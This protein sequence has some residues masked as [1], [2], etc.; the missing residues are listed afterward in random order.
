MESNDKS[1]V[2]PFKFGQI[3]PEKETL[4]TQSSSGFTPMKFDL[5]VSEEE[6]RQNREFEASSGFS[7][8]KVVREH[9]GLAAQEKRDFEERVQKEVQ[10]QL[11]QIK[12]QA[13]EEGFAEG[14]NAG[15][16]KAYAQTLV[17]L[18]DKVDELSSVLSSLQT[19]AHTT[20]EQNKANAYKMVKNLTKWVLLK[21]MDNQD[22]LERLLEKLIY[23]INTKSNL[24]VKVNEN[25]FNY[26]PEIIKK[27]ESRLGELEN[28][29]VKVDQVQSHAGII[30]ESENGIVDG[31][32]ES[33][34]AALDSLFE[35]VEAHESVS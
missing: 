4:H 1:E 2:K 35:S 20:L 11:E 33:Q 7:I 26:M 19:Q 6:I 25:S 15:H 18:E 23:E 13:F 12:A 9:R 34:M 16:E 21:E 31:S 32:I 10:S 8:S 24:I 17:V 3:N 5:K 27:I 22:Y 14:N 28:I 30:L 29:R